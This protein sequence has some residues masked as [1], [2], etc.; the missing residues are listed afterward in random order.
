MLDHHDG[1]VARHL[2]EEIANLLALLLAQAGERLMPIPGQPPNL[3][4]MPPGCAFAPR[5]KYKMPICDE[6]VPL[7]DF[8]DGHVARCY[9][10]DEAAESMKPVATPNAPRIATDAA[11]KTPQELSA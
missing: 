9:L 10:Y 7:Y 1:D 3:L 5:C 2:A 6:A 4:H 8:G 11:G